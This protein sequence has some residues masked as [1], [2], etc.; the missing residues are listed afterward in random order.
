MKKMM[1]AVVAMMLAFGAFSNLRAE[2]ATPDTAPKPKTKFKYRK[3]DSIRILHGK[4]IKISDKSV[5]MSVISPIKGQKIPNVTFKIDADTKM[6]V[7]PKGS[8]LK[9]KAGMTCIAAFKIVDKKR[10]LLQ[11][12]IITKKAEKKSDDENGADQE[13]A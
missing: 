1:L 5:T 10:K 2:D 12:F 9:P 13:A 11:L 4:I 8:E 6:H 3:V 7:S